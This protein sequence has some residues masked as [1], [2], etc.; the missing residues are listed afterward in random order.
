MSC[1]CWASFREL[2]DQIGGGCNLAYRL[3]NK[4]DGQ[5]DNCK[6]QNKNEVEWTTGLTFMVDR[7]YCRPAPLFSAGCSYTGWDCN[8]VRLQTLIY[9]TWI[10]IFKGTLRLNNK[11]QP[12]VRSIWMLYCIDAGCLQLVDRRLTS[13]TWSVGEWYAAALCFMLNCCIKLHTAGFCF[14]HKVS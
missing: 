6:V 10:Q 3:W 4:W 2:F 13:V 7:I 14:Y 9:C 5:N 12:G 8:Q 11:N 1:C